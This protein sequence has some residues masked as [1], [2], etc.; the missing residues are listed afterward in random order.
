MMKSV[1]LAGGLSLFLLGGS[2]CMTSKNTSKS[3]ADNSRTS[4]DWAGTYRGVLPCADC[5]GI[6]TMVYLDGD[7][8]YEISTQYLGKSKETN[9]QKGTFSWDKTGSMITLNRATNSEAAARFKVAEGKLIS[10][11]TKGNPITGALADKYTLQ[12]EAVVI[13]EKYWKLLS[14][15]GKPVAPPEEGQRE[16]HFI[17]KTQDNRVQGNGGCN[18]FTATY[19]LAAGNKITFSPIAATRMF[20]GKNNPETAFFKTLETANHYSLPHEDTLILRRDKEAP[21]AKFAA[22]YF[23]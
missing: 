12:K 5:E 9:K 20:C 21:L 3:G 23:Q 22:V 7:L 2:A 18:T 4:L 14:L 1:L 8:S 19:K 10:L 16:A 6:E 11:D 13:T 17:L 15:A